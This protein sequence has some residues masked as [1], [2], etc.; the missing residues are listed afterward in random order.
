MMIPVQ[1]KY[2]L[3]LEKAMRNL[4]TADHLT[5]ITIPLIKESKLLLK[6]LE[7]LGLS[8]I[9]IINAILQYEY[10]YHRIKLYADARENFTTFKNLTIRYN[11]NPEQLT[12]IIDIL[13]LIE[14]HKTS[15]FEF[16]KN[17]KIVIM[18]EEMKTE[19]LT[20]EKVKNYLLEV[21]DV[22]RKAT[23]S[24]TSRKI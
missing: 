11:I 9:N 18:S 24:L 19:T 13:T 20:I 4:Q 23:I 15:P 3:S 10:L 21:K 22:L 5:Y 7:E 12:K 1:E 2:Q 16:I 17:D 8:L 14:K 6:V